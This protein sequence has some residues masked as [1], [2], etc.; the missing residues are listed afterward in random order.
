MVGLGLLPVQWGVG[1]GCELG[2]MKRGLGMG[3][4]YSMDGAQGQGRGRSL[5]KLS[6]ECIQAACPQQSGSLVYHDLRWF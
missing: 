1:G 6:E 4:G 3:E 2:I 5:I